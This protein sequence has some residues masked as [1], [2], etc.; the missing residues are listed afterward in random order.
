[1]N[2]FEHQER[3]RGSTRKLV[4]LF[5]LAIISLILITTAM[6]V[7]LLSMQDTQDGSAPL[8]D[9]TRLLAG[10]LP[11][12]VLLDVSAVI[13]AVVALGALVRLAQLRGGGK[14][15][16]ESLGGRLLNTGTRDADERKILNVVE[17]M[18]IAAGAP[19][20][21][22]YLIEDSAIN[23][24][25]AGY[26]ARDAVIG[27]TRG[28][29]KLLNRDELQ[30]VI[31]HEFSHIFNGDMRLN[32]RLMGWLYGIT[33]LGLIGYFL[34]RTQSVARVRSSG[35]GGGRNRDGNAL[36]L[37]GIGLVVI[38]YGGTFFGNLIKAAVSR[39]REFLADA[40]AVQYTRNPAGISG[41]LKKI[42]G[43]SQG[44][45]L[46]SVDASEM[47]H[48]LFGQGTVSS[49]FGL[50]ATHPPLGERIRRIEPGWQG[51]FIEPQA[52]LNVAQAENTALAGFAAAH[53]AALVGRVGD[54]DAEHFTSASAQL[55][56]LPAAINEAV[57]TTLGATLLGFGLL[58]ACAD[59][60]VRQRQMDW[61]R[62]RL[63]ANAY[64]QLQTLLPQID[65]LPRPLYLPVLELT[66]PALRALSEPQLQTFLNDLQQF[67]SRDAQLPLFAWCLRH[68]LRASLTARGKR[69]PVRVQPLGALREPAG[70]LLSALASAGHDGED[71]A[72]QAFAAAT[73]ALGLDPAPTLAWQAAPDL[74]RLEAA[75]TALGSLQPL[76]KPRLLEAMVRCVEF[77]GRITPEEHEMVR[78]AAAILDCPMPPLKLAS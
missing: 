21:Q 73:A 12:T 11:Y 13:L 22:V 2:F 40:S 70:V 47:S 63:D 74:N 66:L 35:S 49:L 33:V 6:V 53:S 27:V 45:Q 77:D 39:Q 7:A 10:D 69:A 31:A 17:E 20:P 46:R 68:I 64:R 28:C 62:Q 38:G 54:P 23:A 19:V 60:S 34:L 42:G 37:L 59:V 29:I 57:H 44:S 71:K 24:F 32:I 58:L 76:H 26:Q 41:A 30:G 51:E 43:Y 67:V 78:A 8:I 52:A 56:G 50:F 14:A 75:F 25:A 36:V 72:A 48:M 4:L 61:L 9:M 65:T 1:V 3:A 18:A 15:V 16:A 5:I 55:D